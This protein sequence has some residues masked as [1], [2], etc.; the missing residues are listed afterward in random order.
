MIEVREFGLYEGAEGDQV[1]KENVCL[2][3]Q[4]NIY[5]FVRTKSLQYCAFNLALMH[6]LS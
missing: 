5:T 3:Q 4:F 1:E 2:T 6:H